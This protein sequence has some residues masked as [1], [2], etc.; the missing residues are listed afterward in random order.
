MITR[1]VS[2][3][4]KALFDN[5]TVKVVVNGKH[6]RDV[7]L[8]RGLLQGSVLSPLLYSIFIDDL[9][10]SLR[11]IG[12]DDEKF[13]FSGIKVNS[14]LYADDI[15]LI[16]RSLT[17]LH[18]LLDTCYGHSLANDYEFAVS[19]CALVGGGISDDVVYLGGREVPKAANGIFKY[20]GVPFTAVGVDI[21]KHVYSMCEK[22]KA[23]A[24]IL[25]TIGAHGLGF[26]PLVN[27][28]L[29]KAF[30][31]PV[32]EY[33]MG[34]LMPTKKNV[35]KAVVEV[36]EK[37]QRQLLRK[38]CSLGL[39]TSYHGIL[40]LTGLPTME[41]RI[42]ELSLNCFA[43]FYDAPDNCLIHHVLK[44][45]IAHNYP[46]P[47]GLISHALSNRLWSKLIAKRRNVASK[48]YSETLSTSE[49]TTICLDRQRQ[50]Q[51]VTEDD[52]GRPVG[53][54]AGMIPASLS[55]SPLLTVQPPKASRI[56][57]RR[58]ILWRLSML[59]NA[60]QM[61]LNCTGRVPLTRTLLLNA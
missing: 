57:R 54:I 14:L 17:Y 6:S 30:I 58:L 10:K 40:L 53:I 7:V 25:R 43:R 37:T 33:A 22:A 4:I 3:I 12:Q 9:P 11:L 15:A 41:H 1:G 32:M 2:R 39:S 36:I 19:K 20:L 61:C 48:L 52:L 42:E 49:W 8:G 5:C 21:P 56:Q 24:N 44:Y 16:A 60:R 13:N 50:L 59:F 38:M 34:V 47:N 28:R 27:C 51:R 46:T 26:P 45:E 35:L 18:K 55:P 23:S 29:Y 31:R